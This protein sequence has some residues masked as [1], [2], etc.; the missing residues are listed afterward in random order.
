MNSYP[1]GLQRLLR[2]ARMSRRSFPDVDALREAM[3]PG[4]ASRIVA[5]WATQRNS[6]GADLERFARWAAAAAVCLVLVA[7]RFHVPRSSSTSASP[8]DFFGDVGESV[9]PKP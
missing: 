9:L 3:P 2:L 6:F 4:F 8:D 5:R 7:A 1:P